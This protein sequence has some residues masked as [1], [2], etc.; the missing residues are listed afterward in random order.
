MPNIEEIARTIAR[1]RHGTDA[2][3]ANYV[4]AAEAVLELFK[5]KRRQ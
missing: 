3:W 4:S 1:A 2:M 5:S